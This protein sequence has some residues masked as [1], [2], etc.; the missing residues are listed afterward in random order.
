MRAE[1]ISLAEAIRR[2]R[3]LMVGTPADTNTIVSYRG[4]KALKDPRQSARNSAS[5]IGPH[6]FLIRDARKLLL[7]LTR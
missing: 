6:S 1:G 5:L 7:V 3:N 2:A 4:S